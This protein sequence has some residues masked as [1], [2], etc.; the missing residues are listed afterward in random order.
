MNCILL[1]KYVNGNDST[2]IIVLASM[3]IADPVVKSEE[4]IMEVS[5]CKKVGDDFASRS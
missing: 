5:T 1:Q 3:R 4:L 2:L